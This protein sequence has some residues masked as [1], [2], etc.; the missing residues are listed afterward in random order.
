M[1]GILFFEARPIEGQHYVELDTIRYL[2][3]CH[4]YVYVFVRGSLEGVTLL[5]LLI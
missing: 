2:S 5:C 4:V 3:A 1:L